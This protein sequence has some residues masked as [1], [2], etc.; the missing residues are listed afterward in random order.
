MEDVIT[1]ILSENNIEIPKKIERCNVGADN[2]VYLLNFIDNKK[3]IRLNNEND[4]YNEYQSY[5]YWTTQLQN[6]NIKVPNIITF[7]KYEE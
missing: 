7:G 1:K 6:I 2:Y 5:Q 3:V 4:L